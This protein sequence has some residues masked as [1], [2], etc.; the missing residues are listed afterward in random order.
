MT[1]RTFDIWKR[2]ARQLKL[3]TYTIY[4]AC[5][6]PRVPWYAKILIV[7]VVG[8]AFSPIDKL[9]DPKQARMGR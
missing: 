1:A 7:C 2:R 8:Y 9:L 6:D 5:K 3:E 4:L